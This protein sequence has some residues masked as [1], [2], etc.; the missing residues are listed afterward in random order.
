MRTYVRALKEWRT[1]ARGYL[2]ELVAILLGELEALVL[3]LRY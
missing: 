3:D 2:R 1:Q